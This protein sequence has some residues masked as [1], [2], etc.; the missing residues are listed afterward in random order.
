MRYV[1]IFLEHLLLSEFTKAVTDLIAGYPA[2]AR[3]VV[4]GLA[5]LAW[6]ISKQNKRD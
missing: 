2:W 6:G 3:A 1:Q 5:M 4:L